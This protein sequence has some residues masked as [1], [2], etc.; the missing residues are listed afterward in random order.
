M[1]RHAQEPYGHQ[2]SLEGFSLPKFYSL[3]AL[4]EQFDRAIGLNTLYALV[5]SG[6]IRSVKVG[7]KILVPSS[8]VTEWPRRESERGLRS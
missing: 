1:D 4:Y 6:R 5:R 3:K 7:R 2:Q 8:E